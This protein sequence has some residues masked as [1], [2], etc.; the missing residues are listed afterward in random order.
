MYDTGHKFYGFM[1]VFLN[2]AGVNTGYYGLQDIALKTKM[3]PASGWTIKAD[4][5]HFRTQTEISGSDADTVVAADATLNEAMDE[6]LG[7]EVD[8][9]LVHKYDSNTTIAAGY[10]HY[11]T[12]STFGMMNGGAAGS[13]G[14]AGSDNNDD[15]DWAYV[16]VHTKF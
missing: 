13:G 6:D 10:S 3:S 9:T 5:H 8:L 16:Q 14:T 12:T 11:W 15:A 7:T 1:D 4:Y 2:R